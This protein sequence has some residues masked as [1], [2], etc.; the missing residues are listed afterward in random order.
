MLQLLLE[1]PFSAMDWEE[2]WNPYCVKAKSLFLYLNSCIYKSVRF[3]TFS[4]I[5]YL[6][7][8]LHFWNNKFYCNGKEHIFSFATNVKIKHFDNFMRFFSG[9][10]LPPRWKTVFSMIWHF[11]ANSVTTEANPRQTKYNLIENS[12]LSHWTR[13][14]F[15]IQSYFSVFFWS[16][17]FNWCEPGWPA[18]FAHLRILGSYSVSLEAVEK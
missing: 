4:C 3:H 1:R 10:F 18:F 12:Q 9:F 11:L 2:Q 6:G 16:W 13:S 5:N 14:A 15:A 17:Q 7:I 8:R